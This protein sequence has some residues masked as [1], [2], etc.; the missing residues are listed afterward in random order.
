VTDVGKERWF[1]CRSIVQWPGLPTEQ[2]S[3]EERITIWCATSFTEAIAMAEAESVEYAAANE[4]EDLGI[5]QVFEMSTKV[6]MPSKAANG[7]EVFSLIRDSVLQ[8]DEYLNAFFDT[9]S[10]RQ[11]DVP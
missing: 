1:G 5:T 2:E 3:Y 4:L 9:G 7:V 10:E 8:P 11:R 6:K